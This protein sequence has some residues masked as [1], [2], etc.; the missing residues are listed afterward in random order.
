MK[1]NFQIAINVRQKKGEQKR[2]TL[3]IDNLNQCPI[4]D[5]NFILML[6]KA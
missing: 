5:H 2:K 4:C 1:A 6:N 3:S